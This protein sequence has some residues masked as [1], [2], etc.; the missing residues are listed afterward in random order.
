MEIEIAPS[1][2]SFKQKVKHIWSS[3]K[4]WL[5][6]RWQRRVPRILILPKASEFFYEVHAIRDLL[7]IL[8]TPRFPPFQKFQLR[9][10]QLQQQITPNLRDRLRNLILLHV[11]NVQH[12]STWIVIDSDGFPYMQSKQT[13]TG[14][15]DRHN[16]SICANRA[17]TKILPVLIR[18]YTNSSVEY[19]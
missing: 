8:S 14:D 18:L 11:H 17:V 6:S 5:C 15:Q 10:K 16:K 2:N 7:K 1:S 12:H 19:R 9:T 3:V 4:I 13:G